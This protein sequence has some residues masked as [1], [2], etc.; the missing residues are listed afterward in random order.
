[1][2]RHPFL[3]V[4]LNAGTENAIRDNS[5]IPKLIL[6]VNILI[7]FH[8]LRHSCATMLLNF[9][10][11]LKDIQDWLGHSDIETTAL[12]LHGI[13]DNHK[14]MANQFSIVFANEIA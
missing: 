13:R 11:N 10:Y 14:K 5:P 7:R 3:K 2:L 4:K 8:D 1:M 6:R 12:Y 9:G